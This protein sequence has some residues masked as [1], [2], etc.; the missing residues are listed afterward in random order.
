MNVKLFRRRH[1]WCSDSSCDE[2]PRAGTIRAHSASDRSPSS[3]S[4][5]SLQLQLFAGILGFVGP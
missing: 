3:I 2:D 5:G 1:E 4:C